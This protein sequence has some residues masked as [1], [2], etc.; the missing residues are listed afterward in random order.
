MHAEGRQPADRG[1]PS[2]SQDTDPPRRRRKLEYGGGSNSVN[3]PKEKLTLTDPPGRLKASS[4]LYALS[5]TGEWYNISAAGSPSLDGPYNPGYPSCSS[6]FKADVDTV[7]AAPKSRRLF[8]GR[9]G[10]PSRG[11]I[12]RHMPA[13]VAAASWW[14][15]PMR[16]MR[17][18]D[19][20][21]A[22]TIAS[23]RKPSDRG[24]DMKSQRNDGW[25]GR[26]GT[27]VSFEAKVI[28]GSGTCGEQG[29]A[30]RL[31]MS[32]A[33]IVDGGAQIAAIVQVPNEPVE[34]DLGA[35]FTF[36]GL[37]LRIAC[38]RNKGSG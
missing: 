33:T 27:L 29:S 5:K 8:T 36:L 28:L 10:K 11:G 9:S 23:P 37:Y 20:V 19:G 31:Q 32:V 7:Y 12:G 34:G 13:S 38:V 25:R 6:S 26:N 2:E 1:E 21:A 4:T 17:R 3:T 35:R 15:R 18:T 14:Y 16:G 30:G 24:K 22:R